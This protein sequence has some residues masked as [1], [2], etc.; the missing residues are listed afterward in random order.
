MSIKKYSTVFVEGETE[1]KLFNDFKLLRNHPIKRVIKI[2]LWT[3]D[4]R[5]ILPSFDEVHHIIILFDTDDLSGIKQFQKNLD[6]L[7]VKRHH[8]YLFQQTSNFEH[9][10]VFSCRCNE[11][12]LLSEFCQKIQSLDNFKKAFIKSTTRLSKLEKIGLDKSL[13]WKRGLIEQLSNRSKHISSY[14]DY[15]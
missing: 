1:Q 6:A 9:E 10:L 8:I 11:Q 3:N 14:A 12:K 2:N 4:V 7:L 13:L 5:K 15:F